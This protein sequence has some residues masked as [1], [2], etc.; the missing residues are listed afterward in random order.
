M[1]WVLISRCHAEADVYCLWPVGNENW[2]SPTLQVLAFLDVSYCLP[3][4]FCKPQLLSSFF[5]VI[6]CQTQPIKPPHITN[7]MFPVSSRNITSSCFH[8][9]SFKLPKAIV[10]PNSSPP[11]YMGCH[12]ANKFPHCLARTPVSSSFGFSLWQNSTLSTSFLMSQYRP[13]MPW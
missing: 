13:V 10:S 6:L 7:I 9:S 4:L 11:N 1:G 8:R 5:L 3:F 12:L 2:L